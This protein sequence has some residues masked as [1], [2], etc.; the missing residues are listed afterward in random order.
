MLA[1][2]AQ[3]PDV[4]A[5]SLGREMIDTYIEQYL[6]PVE[7]TSREG[8]ARFRSFDASLSLIDC[9]TLDLLAARLDHLAASLTQRIYREP[10]AGDLVWAVDQAR[11]STRR[12]PSFLNLEYYDLADLLTHLV[13]ETD[14][15]QI[16]DACRR[17]LDQLQ[18]K[19]IVYERHTAAAAS[20]GLAIYFPH[21]SVPESIYNAHQ[22]QYRQTCFSRDT[23]WDELVE[24]SRGG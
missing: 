15:P 16:Q 10:T 20:C 7:I 13:G 3:R 11:R 8:P 23:H 21:R 4:D 17:T 14:D 6:T 9:R 2:L 18:R 19:S 12:Y 5:V 1:T 24:A 22:A